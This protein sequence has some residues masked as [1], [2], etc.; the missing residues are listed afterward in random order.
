MVKTALSAAALTIYL[1]LS[2]VGSA[3]TGKYRLEDILDP[4]AP[5]CTKTLSFASVAS[6]GEVAL[7]PPDFVDKWVRKNQQKYPTLCFSQ[8]VNPATSNYLLIFATSESKFSG[9]HPSLET[10]TTTSRN[11]VSGDGSAHDI[12]GDT[13]R[14]TFDGTVTTTTTTT[15]QVNIPYTDTSRTLYLRSYDQ[16]GHL[17][18]E[19]G[20]TA[21]TRSGGDSS[22]TLGYNL[23]S[24][25]RRIHSKSHLLAAAV[26]D[27]IKH[28]NCYGSLCLNP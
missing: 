26:G 25:L 14:F 24:A 3:Q 16:Q 9:V 17:L 11:P 10:A 23:G 15:T 19:H 7:M 2:M 28:V 4:S 22:D 18:S 8:R 27:V 21:T 20:Y 12:Y 13:W 5:T 1:A 6:N